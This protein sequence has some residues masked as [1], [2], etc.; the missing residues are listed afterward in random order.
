[1]SPS[2]T[3][4]FAMFELSVLERRFLSCCFTFEFEQLCMFIMFLISAALSHHF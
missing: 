1:M 3:V 2:D 4:E